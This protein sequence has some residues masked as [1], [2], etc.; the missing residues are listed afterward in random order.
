MRAD[1]DCSVF[2]TAMLLFGQPATGS[3]PAQYLGRPAYFGSGWRDIYKAIPVTVDP[4]SAL[5]IPQSDLDD[6]FDWRSFE[7][8]DPPF[9]VPGTSRVRGRE[10]FEPQPLQSWEGREDA[11]Q[12]GHFM[13]YRFDDTVSTLQL[14][15]ED[16]F[17]VITLD[18]G[19]HPDYEHLDS[20]KYHANSSVRF[21]V[22]ESLPATLN[23]PDAELNMV[24]NKASHT[25]VLTGGNSWDVQ[26]R[27]HRLTWGLANGGSGSLDSNCTA[28]VEQLYFGIQCLAGFAMPAGHC[29]EDLASAPTFD[30]CVSYCPFT[31][32][33]RA[34]KRHLQHG[35]SVQTLI[36]PGQW[37][38][39][40]LDAG[41]YDLVEVVI[42][43]S[44]YDPASFPDGPWRDGFSGRAW[45][46]KAAC[47]HD[48]SLIVTEHSGE[49][50]H[51]RV[52]S[53]CCT[54]C[55]CKLCEP[56]ACKC[57]CDEHTNMCLS[58]SVVHLFT[59]FRSGGAQLFI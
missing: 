38:T 52:H 18:V 27:R 34:I 54:L 39:F 28:P 8:G 4:V 43:R 10:G 51:G 30:D 44:E 58:L 25:A 33:V 2:M 19:V 46:S 45:L 7:H 48:V 53:F 16:Y 49:C 40:E 11:V 26:T 32:N 13:M 36:G 57:P 59:S 9:D 1:A 23:I 21:T 41:P 50:P 15:M 47:V 20:T 37:Q 42:D 35:D 31:L 55:H 5:T 17:F 14:S 22:Y 12:H 29:T 6:S 24:N 56:A 3:L